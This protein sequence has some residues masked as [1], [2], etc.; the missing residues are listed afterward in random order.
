MSD[1]KSKVCANDGCEVEFVPKVYNAIYCSTACRRIVTNAKI[2]KRYHD[3][4]EAFSKKRICSGFNREC[5]TILSR[6]NKE[7]ICERCKTE[8]YVMRLVNWGWDEKKLREEM[9]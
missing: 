3:N 7:D 1:R 6:Y 2:L 8:R 4:K 5:S 9:Q